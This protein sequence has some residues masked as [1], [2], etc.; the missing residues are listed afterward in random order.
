MT[1]ARY[2]RHGNVITLERRHRPRLELV[3]H[4]YVHNTDRLMRT[5]LGRHPPS[6]TK[7]WLCVLALVGLW[8]LSLYVMK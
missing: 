8:L 2:V 1:Q 5:G 7:D 6:Y 3:Q 4:D